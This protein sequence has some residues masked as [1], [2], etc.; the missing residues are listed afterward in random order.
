MK[1]TALALILLYLAPGL[2]RSEPVI[3]IGGLSKHIGYPVPLR[4][5]HPALGVEYKDFEVAIY[6]NSLDRK[7]IAAAY[8]KRPWS[9]KGVAIGYRIGFA[10]GYPEGTK[11]T[12]YDGQSYTLQGTYKG[13]MPQAQIIFTKHVGVLLID[14]GIAPVSTVTFK[15]KNDI[16]KYI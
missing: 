4:E 6:Q 5:N 3:I 1:L 15:I 11:R 10:T 12:G 16:I 9:Y 2:A 14:V 8:I 7:S 13:V